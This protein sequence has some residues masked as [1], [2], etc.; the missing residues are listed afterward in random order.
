MAKKKLMDKL[1]EEQQGNLYDYNR[2]SMTAK[3]RLIAFFIGFAGAAIVLHIFFGNFIVDVVAGCVTGVIAQ[4]IYRKMMIERQ[5]KKLLLQFRDLLDMLGTSVSAA[6]TMTQAFADAQ[7][8]LEKQYGA[9]S[10][11][12][13]EL[14]VINLGI[15]YN[16]TLEDLLTDFGRRSGSEDIVSFANVFVMSNRRTSDM[17]QIIGETKSILC[18]KIDI[19]QDIQASVSAA[20]S[21]L[22]IVILM[23]LLVVP[24]MSSFSSDSDNPLVNIGVKIFGLAAFI[25]AYL[26]GRKIT[27]IK[28]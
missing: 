1:E 17:K 12:V 9:D 25:G 15:K 6:L 7:N 27:N 10:Y 4:K 26:I 21:E 19:E 13:R 23:P 8:E 11:I 3:D 20:R 2:Y 16:N 18:D 24:L 14:N 22:N 5:K 28:V